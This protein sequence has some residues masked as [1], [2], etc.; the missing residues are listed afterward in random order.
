MEASYT[1]DVEPEAGILRFVLRGFFDDATIAAF[2][3]DRRVAF[4]KL[5]TPPNQHLTLVDVSECAIQSQEAFERFRAL[6]AEPRARSR[7]MAFVV[8]S[9]LARMQIRRL[10]PDRP[11]ISAFVSKADAE[12]W[13]MADERVRG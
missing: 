7:R 6:L 4:A 1:I 2:I 11:E 8:G 5:R 10:A 12:A 3:A 13:L 9:S